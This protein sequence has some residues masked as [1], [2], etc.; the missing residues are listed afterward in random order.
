MKKSGEIEK[1]D[2]SHRILLYD[3][4]K[5]G[6]CVPQVV[7]PELTSDLADEWYKAKDQAWNK[8]MK[9]IIE[10]RAS[11]IRLYIEYNHMN[12][13]DAAARMG[14]S[15]SAV[16]KHM[17]LEGFKAL[18]VRTLGKYAKVFNIAVCSLFQF[19]EYE[20]KVSLESH[21]YHDGVIQ[22]LKVSA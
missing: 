6:K 13:E 19:L 2:P 10:G 15:V 14:L 12:V 5:G 20:G 9:E 18:D 7:N 21:V 11:P 1:Y 3:T 8:I 22:V 16:N 17:T 4:D